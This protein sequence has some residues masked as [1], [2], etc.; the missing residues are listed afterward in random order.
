M[1]NVD[2]SIVLVLSTFDPTK[3][4]VEVWFQ[5]DG[6][7][8]RWYEYIF[9]GHENSYIVG[10]T[11]LT[12]AAFLLLTSP[13]WIGCLICVMCGSLL[14]CGFGGCCCICCCCCRPKKVK[15]GIIEEPARPEAIF[16]ETCISIVQD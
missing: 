14:G 11:F 5:V 13:V 16:E 15:L 4:N 8:Y 6:P 12:I 3:D 10:V 9:L 7:A 2:D 1:T